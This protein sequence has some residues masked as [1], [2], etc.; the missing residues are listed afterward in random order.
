VPLFIDGVPGIVEDVDIIPGAALEPVSPGTT[1]Q[2]V[3]ADPTA[4]DVV[5]RI[6]QN[7]VV[8]VAAVQRVDPAAAA[9]PVVRT[10]RRC[11]APPRTPRVAVVFHAGLTPP[12][13]IG[14]PNPAPF[15]GVPLL[16]DHIPGIVDDVDV[17]PG[18]ADQPVRTDPAVQDVGR[19]IAPEVIGQG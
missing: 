2:V 13:H 3:V 12:Q 11:A 6:A 9:Q 15:G 14:S 8:A 7:R 5:A 4:Q 17:V 16:S 10:A 18:T 19:G 1:V